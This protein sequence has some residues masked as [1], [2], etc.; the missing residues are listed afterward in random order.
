[1]SPQYFG[2]HLSRDAQV[3]PGACCLFSGAIRGWAGPEDAD[4]CL[5]DSQEHKK[6]RT[7]RRTEREKT[8]QELIQQGLL[9]APKPKVK[10][11]NMMR[12]VAEQAVADPTA[13]EHDIRSQMAE[14]QQVGWSLRAYGSLCQ[15]HVCSRCLY[16][17][18]FMTM[19]G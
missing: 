15:Q 2:I 8:R 17:R 12:V 4:W 6:L 14:R 13:M 7:Q 18:V 1:M 10:L 5:I 9:E 19:S 3:E 11:G 16:G